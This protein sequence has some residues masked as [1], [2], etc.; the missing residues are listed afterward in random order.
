MQQHV[1]LKDFSHLLPIPHQAVSAQY[2]ISFLNELPQ[3]PAQGQMNDLHLH[4]RQNH[5]IHKI[6]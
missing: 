6:H 1:F 3:L 4:I 2:P 5:P